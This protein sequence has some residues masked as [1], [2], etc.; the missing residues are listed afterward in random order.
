MEEGRLSREETVSVLVL[1]DTEPDDLDE[2]HSELVGELEKLRLD[3]EVLYLVRPVARGTIVKLESLQQRDP[4]RVR[5]L[6]FAETAGKTSMLAA[7]IERAR[8]EIVMTIPGSFEIDLEILGE[9]YHAVR[10]DADLASATRSRGP[11]GS[12][13]RIQ[14]E[15]F[16]RLVS[17]AASSRFRD[18]ASETRAFRRQVAEET[19]LYGD[20]DRY[21]PV[22][23]ERVGFRVEEIPARQ[24]PRK[25][26]PPL[27]RP[28]VY[29]WRAIDLL[30][31]FFISR[32][33]RHPLRLFGGLGSLFAAIGSVILLVVG[34]QR[35]AG[36]S[37]AN[38]PILVLGTLLIGLGV[39]T[40]AIG[41]LGELILFFQARSTRDYRVSAVYEANR[42]L[43]SQEERAGDSP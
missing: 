24:H 17:L 27:F 23:A 6:H 4:E 14:S 36:V 25:A 10:Q 11:V 2:I 8:G 26:A 7:G 31:I 34:I 3:Y 16:N 20:F 19:P 40:F 43:A 30:S 15:V 33:T 32:F 42:S 28:K 41:L 22:F 35:L 9:L 13:A 29:F 1:V 21:L 37:L 38:R 5:A 12:S 18:V 39:Q